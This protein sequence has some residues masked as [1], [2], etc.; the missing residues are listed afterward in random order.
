VAGRDHFRQVEQESKVVGNSYNRSLRLADSHS[1]DKGRKL[2]GTFGVRPK[3]L[4]NLPNARG[5]EFKEAIG[6]SREA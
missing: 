4:T 6:M 2:F 3:I 5:D 1:A